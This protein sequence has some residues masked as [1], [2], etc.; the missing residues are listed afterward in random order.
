MHNAKALAVLTSAVLLLPACSSVDVD[1]YL[2]DQRLEYKK[3]REA[4]DNLEIPPDLTAGSFDDAMDVP[5]LGGTG[6]ATYSEYVGEQGRRRQV[7][8]S[9]DVLPE[10]QDVT[11]RRRGDNRWLEIKA[12]PQGVWPRVIDFWRSQGILLV[13]QDPTAGIMKTDWLENRAEIR[14][15]FVTNVI[16]K[17]ADGLYA[18]STRDQ[19]RVRIEPG[20]SAGTT[21]L[22]LTHR[23]MEERFRS[24]AA[25]EDT[26]TVW[27]P[28]DP[29][30]GKEAAMLR[31]LM[32]YLGVSETRAAG[33]VAQS[34]PASA[35]SRLVTGSGGETTL[36]IDD[37]YRR[38]W[39]LTGVALDRIGFA[40]EDRDRTQ[41]VYYVR[42]DDPSKGEEKKGWGSKLAF[43][44]SDEVDTLTRY[45]VKL[46]GDGA[47]TR[48]VVRDQ[49]GRPDPSAT[50]KRILTLLNEQIR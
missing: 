34:Q 42:Y 9:G 35:K 28:T 11:L 50:S 31:R 15:D 17:V 14:R 5:P 10:V 21:D 24:N 22:Y 36:V 23:A 41:G 46:T 12:S 48:V 19:Y 25:G 44:R 43:W 4:A 6:T 20:L 2:P 27:E 16:R 18:T 30:P 45:Q 32:V 29:D 40:V 49:V 7:A 1:D 39:R 33:Q 37:E 38:A 26:N 47:Q 3:Q 8:T 13:E